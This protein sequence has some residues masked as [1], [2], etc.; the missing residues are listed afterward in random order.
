METF[1]NDADHQWNFSKF[2]FERL[3][4]GDLKKGATLFDHCRKKKK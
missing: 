2:K 4:L 1:P 3:M